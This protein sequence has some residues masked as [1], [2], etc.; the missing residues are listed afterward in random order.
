MQKVII[1]EDDFLIAD[2]LEEVLVTA[3]YDVCGL[4]ST[5]AEAVDLCNRLH[6]DL[7][8]IDVRLGAGGVGTDVAAQID[9]RANLGILY[10][11]GNA[12]HVV[13]TA[14]DGEACITKPYLPDDI[15]RAL[16]IVSEVVGTGTT[17]AP[18]PRNFQLLRKAGSRSLPRE[19]GHGAA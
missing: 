19:V 13:L 4:A 9:S 2:L 6:P 1:A 17:S 3:G 15:V 7:A 5:V 14:S 12:G 10:A 8:V 11:T 16:R 18:F